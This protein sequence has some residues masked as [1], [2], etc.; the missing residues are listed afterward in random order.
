MDERE[1]L[2]ESGNLPT[3]THAQSP[4]TYWQPEIMMPNLACSVKDIHA[5]RVEE[6]V[7]KLF[8]RPYQGIMAARHS[9]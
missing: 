9:I 2:M 1:F 7:R 4:C 8:M 3:G 6:R 5:P